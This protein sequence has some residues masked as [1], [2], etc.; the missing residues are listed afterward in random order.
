MNW[1]NRVN[2]YL[3]HVVLECQIRTNFKSTKRGINVSISLKKQ[4]KLTEVYGGLLAIEGKWPFPVSWKARQNKI[5]LFCLA[6]QETGKGHFPSL[7]NEPMQTELFTV[8][9]HTEDVVPTSR[10]PTYLWLHV[11]DM[12]FATNTTFMQ[13]GL[14]LIKLFYKT[15]HTCI[16]HFCNHNVE[17]NRLEGQT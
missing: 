8:I 3:N 10:R 6:F 2:L 7:A 12:T 1:F 5:I 16:M 15:Q 9:K 13:T 11:I 14:L 17:Q 4:N